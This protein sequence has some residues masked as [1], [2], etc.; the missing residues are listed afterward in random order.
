MVVDFRHSHPAALTA[1]SHQRAVTVGNVIFGFTGRINTARN[2]IKFFQFRKIF[3][4]FFIGIHVEINHLVITDVIH[5]VVL[6]CRLASGLT[7]GFGLGF[8]S[9]G[10]FSLL[11]ALT[12]LLGGRGGLFLGQLVAHN[13]H[14]AAHFD[15]WRV[16]NPFNGS[17]IRKNDVNDSV[18][19]FFRHN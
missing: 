2:T 8:V 7:S 3:T 19:G 10:C 16:C 5:V 17:K 13:D 18:F 1:E 11:R 6:G 9:Y 14:I 12:G 4:A 15:C